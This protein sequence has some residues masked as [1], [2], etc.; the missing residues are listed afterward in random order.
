MFS[1]RA[2][3]SDGTAEAGTLEAADRNEAMR[4]LTQ[5]NKR[6][7]ALTEAGS[8][9]EGS[10]KSAIRLR[11]ADLTKLFAELAVLLD[12]GFNVPAALRIYATAERLPKRK[13]LLL[14]ISDQISSGKALA[15]AFS[16]LP[17]A[18]PDL[19]ALIASGESSGKLPD[20]VTRIAETYRRRSERRSA[21]LEALAY[22]AFLLVM[23]LAALLF[24]A[25]FLMPAIEP[26]FDTGTIDKPIAVRFLAGVGRL[27]TEQWPMLVAAFVALFGL[28][29]LML[30]RPATRSLLTRS[31]FKIPGIGRFWKDGV[32][33]SYLETLS[34]L[35]GNG[36]P[37]ID[38]LRLAGAVCTEPSMRAKLDL[39]RDN[40]A[41]G[42][43]LQTSLRKS[44]LFDDATLTL[45]GMGE[46]ANRLPQV[47]GRAS[48]LID[49]RL[50][51]AVDRAVGFLSPALTIG[52]GVMIGGLVV[53]VMT[54]L[55][56]INEMAVQ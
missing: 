40:V 34:L 44:G 33:V 3:R 51:R 1:Y 6:P 11:T 37:M 12:A 41:N 38:A 9:S 23:V 26:I 24:L 15:D 18:T 4:R 45:I 54:A 14:A 5:A 52:L 47:L 32:L 17:G 55:L 13:A 50:K 22:P 21:I 43:Q 8:R 20:V 31:T 39:A 10:S 7:F 16:Q 19:V 53:S 46:Q 27:F 29:F 30:Q 49:A 2:Y 48:S 28:A 25:L 36:V 56:S 42:E 35:A